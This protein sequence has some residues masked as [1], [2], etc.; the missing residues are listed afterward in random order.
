MALAL[1]GG[2]APTVNYSPYG[3]PGTTFHN[4]MTT[5]SGAQA[6]SGRKQGF[7]DSPDGIG[8]SGG[9]AQVGLPSGPGAG[10]LD[11]FSAATENA[12]VIGN[13]ADYQYLQK[14]RQPIDLG[15]G[16]NVAGVNAALSGYSGFNPATVG[17]A[18]GPQDQIR[19]DQLGF[20]DQLR[21]ASLGQGPSAAG[22]MLQR[23]TDANINQQASIAASLRGVSNP[24][25]QLNAANNAALVQARS[26]ADA[27]V[28]AAQE[29]IAARGQYGGALQGVRGQDQNLAQLKAQVGLQNQSLGLQAQ[30]QRDS[31]LNALRQLQFGYSQLG[32]SGQLGM[33]GLEG[34]YHL[35]QDQL[36]AQAKANQPNTW[37]RVAQF[38]NAG[39]GILDAVIPG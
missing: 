14:L 3:Q 20:L 8:G 34:Q 26:G 16:G 29:Q 37:D 39:A 5:A 23:D 2:Y 30:A 9:G 13:R 35:T 24:A 28:L 15:F 38:A 7:F 18:T 27:R 36:Q 19:A 17:V 11:P 6:K 32:Q 12:K 1:A 25:A 22:A 31:A 10:L 4:P 21:L 33:L